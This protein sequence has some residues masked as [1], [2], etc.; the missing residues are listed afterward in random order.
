MPYRITCMPYRI[1]SMRNMNTSNRVSGGVLQTQKSLRTSLLTIARR[2]L[3]VLFAILVILFRQYPLY[4][5]HAAKRLMGLKPGAIIFS[6]LSM[7]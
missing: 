6:I 5:L 2:T 3:T 7:K 1:T 4:M